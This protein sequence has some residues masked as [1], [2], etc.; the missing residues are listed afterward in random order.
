MA[1]SF[2]IYTAS[3]GVGYFGFAALFLDWG[4]RETLLVV[5]TC[6]TALGR[7]LKAD[8]GQVI[9]VIDV[10]NAIGS[11]ANIPLMAAKAWV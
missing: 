5:V 6:T 11:L 4:D 8:D 1:G 9:N 3:W 10:I 7:R 2:S